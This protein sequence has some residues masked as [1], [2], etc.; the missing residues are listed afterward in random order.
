[1]VR[2]GRWTIS[3]DPPPIPVREM[4]FMGLHDDFDGAPTDSESGC[5]DRRCVRGASVEDVLEQ[6]AELDPC[7]CGEITT[8][9]C[10]CGATLCRECAMRGCYASQCDRMAARIDQ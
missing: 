4:D 9:R 8:D 10:S 3:Y 7:G 6:I 5:T 1:M 2:V